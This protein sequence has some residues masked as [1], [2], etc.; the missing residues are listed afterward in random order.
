MIRG[1]AN[2]DQKEVRTRIRRSAIKIGADTD[3]VDW[4]AFKRT[5]FAVEV[6]MESTEVRML[7]VVEVRIL[8][9][10]YATERCDQ[11]DW[12]AERSWHRLKLAGVEWC[13]KYHGSPFVSLS[14]LWC[15]RGD[16]F[17][18]NT[19]IW[20]ITCFIIF[21]SGE[22]RIRSKCELVGRL[23]QFLWNTS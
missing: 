14:C 9:Q 20:G 8:K 6:R 1:G 10:R 12:S 11:D 19:K 3:G 18:R 23:L 2:Y 5:N 17:Q 13:V 7:L 4:G 21:K 16:L 15:C 22:R